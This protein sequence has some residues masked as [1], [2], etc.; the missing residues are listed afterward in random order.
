[1]IEDRWIIKLAADLVLSGIGDSMEDVLAA[2]KIARKKSNKGW[3]RRVVD[4]V[5]G[6]RG[7]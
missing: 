4:S 2:D 5:V 3:N 7:G 1:M 6:K